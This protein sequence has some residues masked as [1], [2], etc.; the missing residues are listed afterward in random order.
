MTQVVAGTVAFLAIVM[1]AWT[2]LRFANYPAPWSAPWHTKALDR[3]PAAGNAALRALVLGA[4][5]VVFA[6]PYVQG[7]SS[8]IRVRPSPPPVATFH[9]GSLDLTWL[10]PVLGIACLVGLSYLVARLAP[11]GWGRRRKSA[12]VA[13]STDIATLRDLTDQALL[14]LLTQS[15]P[16]RAILA[17]YALMESGLAKRGLPRSPEETALEY[18]RR[19]LATAGAPP[20]ALRSLTGLFELAGFSGHAINETMRQT[21]ISSLRAIGE[22]TQ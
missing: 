12:S 5:A 19:L 22:A 7:P 1:Y 10:L 8:P 13:I 18:A 17:C 4:L 2:A 16:R 6:W 20:A 15:D 11:H 9:A 14:E 21:A 3:W